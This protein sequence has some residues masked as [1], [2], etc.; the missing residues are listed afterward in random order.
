MAAAPNPYDAVPYPSMLLPDCQPARLASI[1]KLHGLDPAPIASAR[2]L[3][4]GGGDGLNV[5]ALAAAYPNAEFLNIDLAA[6]PIARG[7]QWCRAVGIANAQHLVMDILD[8]PDALDGTFDYIFA[9]GVYAWVPA[10][11]RE[12]LMALFGRLLS[13]HGVAY[14]SYNA[15][16]GGYTRLALRDL[17]LHH[18]GRIADPRER[19]AA[20]RRL[21]EQFVAPGNR[22]EPITAAM[23]KE[24]EA[25]LAQTDGQLFHDQ[26]GPIYAP[27][28]LSG[29]V[30][31]ANRHGLRYLGDV[32]RGGQEQGFVDP[33]RAGIGDEALVHALQARDFRTGRYFRKSLFVRHDAPVRRAIDGRFAGDMWVSSKALA[34][35]DSVFG[36]GRAQRR[37]NSQQLAAAVMRLIEA[38]PKRLPVGRVIADATL[39][40]DLIDLAVSGYVELH[41]APA[42]F[43]SAAGDQPEASALAR[44]QIGTGDTRICT[45]AHTRTEIKDP[46]FRNAIMLFDGATT[47][48]ELDRRWAATP[49]KTALPLDRALADAARLAL[50]HR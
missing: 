48:E 26:L 50:L 10:P 9:H 11:V 5:I 7:T 14:V 16:P 17:I 41:T 3:E 6:D 23:R 20:T 25:T 33:D 12:G 19:L 29:T 4:V 40:E 43:A 1:A 15:L 34:L 31:A 21:L 35:G 39:L 2:T 47:R 42:P 8:A 13:P 24:A 49:W 28:S 18:V 45:L 30:A 46:A 37:I 32:S 44:M 22:D 38:S 36:V 27:Q